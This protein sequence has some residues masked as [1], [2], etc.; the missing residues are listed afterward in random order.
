MYLGSMYLMCCKI[1]ADL[2]LKGMKGLKA[3][4]ARKGV[5][6]G[7]GGEWKGLGLGGHAGP[8]GC[9]E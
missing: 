4:G 9:K 2:G 7:A 8:A 3:L 6:K 5:G 1:T